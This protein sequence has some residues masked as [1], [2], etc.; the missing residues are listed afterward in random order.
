MFVPKEALTSIH[1]L[2]VVGSPLTRDKATGRK[3]KPVP[4]EQI[5]LFE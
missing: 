1:V 5:R 2:G 3:R 4:K